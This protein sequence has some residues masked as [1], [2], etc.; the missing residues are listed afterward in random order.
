MKKLFLTSVLCLGLAH[1]HSQTIVQT[2]T[3]DYIDINIVPA[4]N[5]SITGRIYTSNKLVYP[6]YKGKRGG[7]YIWKTSKKGNKYKK[8]LKV[9]ANGH[10]ADLKQVLENNENNL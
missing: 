4:Y 9:S 5:D 2:S 3:G 8:Y 7:I 6:V 10:P 1:A